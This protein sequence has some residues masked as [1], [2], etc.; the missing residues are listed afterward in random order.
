[1]FTI[2]FYASLLLTFFNYYKTDK[3]ACGCFFEDNKNKETC[4]SNIS[5]LNK[6]ITILIEGGLLNDA[7]DAQKE[8]ILNIKT[9]HG[10]KSW[11]LKSDASFLSELEVISNADEKREMII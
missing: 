11:Q 6:K 1:M 3:N 2:C 7:I 8:K 4:L 10:D 9:A 5:A